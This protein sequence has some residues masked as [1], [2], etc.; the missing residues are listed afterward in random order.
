MDKLT[1]SKKL[2]IELLTDLKKKGNGERESAAFLM[3]PPAGRNI[4][5]FI[6]LDELDPYSFDSG[7]I[8]FDTSG[9][10]ILWKI[11]EAEGLKVL[12]DIHTHPGSYTSQSNADEAHPM[13][14]QAGHIAIIVPNF[15]DKVQ[16][17]L[18][19][20][21]VF[22]YLGSGNWKTHVKKSKAFKIGNFK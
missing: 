5:K 6:C 20:V 12:A 11:C 1:I 15:A 19:G 18:K 3:G 14:H 2:W 4:T 13:I 21:G 10:V 22:E 8:R 16:S 7:I 17:S 9:F